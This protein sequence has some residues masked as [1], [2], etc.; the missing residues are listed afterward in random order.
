M[1][2]QLALPEPKLSKNERLVLELLQQGGKYSKAE[3][4]TSRGVWNVGDICM[5]LRRKGFPVKTEMVRKGDVEFGRYYLE[6]MKTKA[7]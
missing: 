1:P 2:E 5:K 6:T 7:A 3:I 4:W